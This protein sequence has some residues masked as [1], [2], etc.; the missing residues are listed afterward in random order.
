[1]S[2]RDLIMVFCEKD[3]NQAGEVWRRLSDVYKNELQASCLTFKFPGSGQKEQPVIT[4]Q[5]A[6]KLVMYLPGGMAPEFLL[7]ACEIIAR[8]IN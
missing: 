6:L 5:G 3:G 2:I 8:V 7:K 4:L 1:M